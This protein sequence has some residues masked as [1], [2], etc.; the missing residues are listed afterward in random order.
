MKKT[1]IKT[2]MLVMITGI[3]TPVFA[4]NWKVNSVIEVQDDH[5]ADGGTP[6][7]NATNDKITITWGYSSLGSNTDEVDTP[8]AYLGEDTTFSANWNNAS[9]IKNHGS[10]QNGVYAG[11]AAYARSKG[12]AEFY[13]DPNA[14][15]QGTIPGNTGA[16]IVEWTKHWS[17]SFQ[18]YAG[19]NVMFDGASPDG[20]H[21]S[22]TSVPVSENSGNFATFNWETAASGGGYS[23]YGTY[24]ASAYATWRVEFDQLA[25]DY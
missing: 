23:S 11:R 20:T 21:E 18:G 19:G 4:G 1:L 16:F 9:A 15:S 17:S 3:A 5:V 24:S 25:S 6:W 13:W 7:G 10:T 8:Y 2:A 12:H 14:T 22:H